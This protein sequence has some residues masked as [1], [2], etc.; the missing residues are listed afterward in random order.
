MRHMA[1]LYGAVRCLLEDDT[2]VRAEE[3]SHSVLRKSPSCTETE[4][5]G[6]LDGVTVTGRGPRCGVSEVAARV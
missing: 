1:R 2:N 6:T 3:I 5:R 4:G